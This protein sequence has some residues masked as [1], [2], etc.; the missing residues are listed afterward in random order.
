M[1]YNVKKYQQKLKNLGFYKDFVDGEYGPN[2][3]KAVE[4]FQRSYG[5]EIDGIVGP[6]TWGALF[7]S[8]KPEPTNETPPW[9]KELLALDGWHEHVNKKELIKWLKSDGSTVGDPSKIPWCGDAIETAIKLTIP[10]EPLPDVLIKNP[11]WAQ[12]W[13]YFGVKAQARYGSILVFKR[14]GGGHVGFYVGEN[15]THYF[16]LG[17]N[18][19]NKITISKIAKSR[20]IAIRWPSTVDINKY[21]N[22]SFDG[23]N[24]ITSTNEK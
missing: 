7:P 5:I 3:K 19:S 17:G 18:Q 16:V 10:L 9:V 21:P 13:Q 22:K 11:Y 2:T 15:K 6:E 23:K 20:C 14:N 12:N 4:E 8:T 1:K 24:L